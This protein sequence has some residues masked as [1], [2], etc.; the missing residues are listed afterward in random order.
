MFPK[1]GDQEE[2]EENANSDT[3]DL[4]SLI[5]GKKVLNT[6]HSS[7]VINLLGL[8]TS[9]FTSHSWFSYL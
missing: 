2:T 7:S 1:N 6:G 4:P 8:N 3:L 5:R 9:H